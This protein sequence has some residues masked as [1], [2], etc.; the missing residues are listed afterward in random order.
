MTSA[1]RLRPAGDERAF[2]IHYARV[3]LNEARA[4]RS[5]R[6]F[7]FFLLAA[8][9]RARREAAAIDLRPRQADLFR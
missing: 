5:D 4:R 9:A 1:A 8:A 6:S 7:S 3:M 2:L